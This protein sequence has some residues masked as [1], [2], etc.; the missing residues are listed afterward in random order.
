MNNFLTTLLQVL[1]P[2][3]ISN[4]SNDVQLI[5]FFGSMI[6][7]GLIA[8]ITYLK[9]ENT[10]KDKIIFTKEKKNDDIIEKMHEA[11]KANLEVLKDVVSII[12]N[13]AATKSELERLILKETNPDIKQI[14]REIMT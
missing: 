13:N 3:L 10:A 5:Y 4:Q 6:V 9:I 14:L 7:L 1:P 11:E 2:D 12:K 8:A